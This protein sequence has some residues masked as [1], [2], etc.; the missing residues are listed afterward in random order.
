MEAVGVNADGVRIMA[1]KAEFR[2]ILVKGLSAGAANV[3]KQQMLSLGGEAAVASGAVN[4]SVDESD[5]LLA[6]TE[7]QMLR[8]AESLTRQPFGLS[9]L[10]EELKTILGPKPEKLVCAGREL[11]LK[12]PLVMGILN[13][14]PDSF[15]DGGDFFDTEKAIGRAKH[16]LAEGADIIDVGGESTRP[17]SAY[18]DEEEELRRVMPVVEAVAA[19]AVISVDTRK[20]IVARKALDAGAAMVNDISA[21]R[22]DPGVAATAAEFGAA[23]ILMHM[24]GT[25]AD[26]QVDPRYDDVVGE[27][28]DFLAER[29]E[30][31]RSEGVESVVVDPGIGFGKTLEHNLEL[32]RN[33]PAITDLGYPVLVGHSRKSFIEMLLGLPVE[34]RLAPSLA[35]AVEAARRGANVLRVHDVKETVEA[36]AMARALR[37]V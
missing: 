11:S 2:T 10:G 26:M 1:P 3:V 29:A 33:T 36:L 19:D 16:I 7:K 12:R 27:V 22:D 8:L 4:C 20:S 32:L 23:L 9:A 5:A 34:E 13:V 28:R 25:P 24:L 35:V 31:A 37:R 14:T 18:V 6:G 17:G 30:W 21:G 15:S